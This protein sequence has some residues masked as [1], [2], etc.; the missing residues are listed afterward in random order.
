LQFRCEP[1][2]APSVPAIACD[3]IAEVEGAARG[4]SP[5]RRVQILRQ[6]T[7]LFLADP[8]RL[9]ER[10]TLPLSVAQWTIRFGSVQDFAGKFSPTGNASTGDGADT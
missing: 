3:I 10:Q 7:G 2:L 8:A 6:M 5:A 1:E 9:N 4:G